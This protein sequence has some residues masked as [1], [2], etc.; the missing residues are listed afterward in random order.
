MGSLTSAFSKDN[1]IAVTTDAQGLATVPTP[2]SEYEK[3]LKVIQETDVSSYQTSAA[4]EDYPS[5]ATSLR[6]KVILLWVTSNAALVTT[7]FSV[8]AISKF[9]AVDGGRG[10]IYIGVVLW[11]NVGLLA[12][13]YIG[14]LC[15]YVSKAIARVLRGRM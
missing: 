2:A 5:Y 9:Q 12:T 4:T 10:F 3:H 13:Q 1:A 11:M 15:Y 14:T 7:V 8:P 6:T